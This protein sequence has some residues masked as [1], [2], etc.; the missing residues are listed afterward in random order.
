MFVRIR[1][2]VLGALSAFGVVSYLAA[3]VKRARQQLTPA[4]LVRRGGS[5][6][7]DALETTADRLDP[8][9]PVG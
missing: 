8:R 5:S 6:V 4:N 1:W 7:A 2:F 3:Q 9:H